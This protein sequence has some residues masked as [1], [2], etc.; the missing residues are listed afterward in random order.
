MQ[1]ADVLDVDLGLLVGPLGRERHALR[2]L[3]SRHVPGLVL[4]AKRQLAFLDRLKADERR[5]V[6]ALPKR[7]GESTY[8]LVSGW[9][10][11]E[12]EGAMPPAWQGLE[13]HP[14]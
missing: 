6:V 12:F 13:P 2:R 1:I 9:E 4:A 14:A 5:R 7:L 3:R 11:G 8:V 10:S